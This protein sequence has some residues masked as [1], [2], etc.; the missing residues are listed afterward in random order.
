MSVSSDS[1]EGSLHRRAPSLATRS[2]SATTTTEDTVE[3][4]GY[5]TERERRRERQAVRASSPQTSGRRVHVMRSLGLNSSTMQSVS[6]RPPS[7]SSQTALVNEKGGI[8]DTEA[9]TKEGGAVPPMSTRRK[10]YI[11]GA[12]LVVVLLIAAAVVAGV[13][14]A[15][16]LQDLQG[17]DE[18]A[19]ILASLGVMGSSMQGVLQASTTKAS[20]TATVPVDASV[21]SS[22][23][24]YARF[25]ELHEMLQGNRDFRSESAVEEPGLIAELA[26]GQKPKFA[27]LGCSDS[28]V[29]ETTVLDANPG[30]VFVTRNIGN[31]YTMDDL[32]SET[33]F[34]YALTHILPGHTECGAVQAAIASAPDNVHTNM[35]HTRVE[36]WIRPIRRI[37]ATSERS[38]IS[39][40]RQKWSKADRVDAANVTNDVW[41]ALVEENVKST[42]ERIKLDPTVQRSWAGYLSHNAS[43]TV[44]NTADLPAATQN[45]A[46]THLPLFAREAAPSADPVELWVH[47]W[48]YDVSTG[49]VHDLGISAGPHGAF[50][51][52]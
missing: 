50:L 41:N 33:V 51:R 34:S 14:M 48:V 18:T 36:T 7:S 11:A 21:P 25:P 19:Q 29:P 52:K 30:D 5:Q 9:Q 45:S 31:L 32:S 43:N 16:R 17:S 4:E 42:V 46:G 40:F 35:D 12:V 3:E 47:G 10:V 26:K 37:Y 38:E 15:R 24:L 49:I 20:G 13:S 1:D 6:S 39:S 2:D 27:Y 8:P 44:T 23:G 22:T 28:R